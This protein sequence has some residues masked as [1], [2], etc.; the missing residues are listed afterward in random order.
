M[1][2]L[3][4]GSMLGGSR[5]ASSAGASQAAAADRAAQLSNEQYYQ[6]RADQAPFREGGLAAQNRLMTLLGIS[7][8]AAP[9]GNGGG[10]G[11]GG[12]G[13]LGGVANATRNSGAIPGTGPSGV[14]VDPN[15]PD[16]G[17][18]ARDF[19]AA[20]FQADPG[21]AFRLSEGQKALD[22]SAAARG[23]L[24]SGGALKAATRFGQDMGSQE[25]QN[26]Y[27]RYQTNRSNQLNPLQSL[28]GAGQTS[29]N[30][31]GQAGAA[32]AANVGNYMTGGAAAQAA[33]Q[34]GSANAITGGINSYL[35]YNQSNNL[36]AALRGGSGGGADYSQVTNPYF[37]SGG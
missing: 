12:F 9:V 8:A 10:G 35:N 13:M 33:G 15:S 31:L 30:F 29:T 28:M 3:T 24:I 6:T 1:L 32:N 17:K 25:F 23:G 37:T 18:Y 20:D 36:L 5:A 22:R 4:A 11:G 26:A 27:N 34:V 21:Y 2:G 14:V 16:Y 7:P 19:G